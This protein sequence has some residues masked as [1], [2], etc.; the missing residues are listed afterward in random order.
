MFTPIC[1]MRKE[2]TMS[3]KSKLLLAAAGLVLMC[4]CKNNSA[5]L[6]ETTTSAAEV[7]TAK[8]T[9]PAETTKQSET[10]TSKA[11]EETTAAQAEA[12]QIDFEYQPPQEVLDTHFYSDDI[13]AK[14]ECEPILDDDFRDVFN[15]EEAINEVYSAISEILPQEIVDNIYNNIQPFE[16]LPEYYRIKNVSYMKYDLNSDGTDDYYLYVEITDEVMGVMG[17]FH[18]ERVF[19][20]DGD[21]FKPI[22]IPSFNDSRTICYYILSTQTNGVKDIFAFHNSNAPS[23]KY[24]S[25][26]AYGDFTELD[27]RHTFIEFEILSNNILYLN[28]KVS[29]IDAAVGEY[30]TAIQ[31]ADNTYL[32]NSMLYSCYSDGTPRSYIEKSIDEWQSGDFYPSGEGYDFYVELTDEGVEAFTEETNVWRLLDLLEIKYIAVDE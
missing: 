1:N 26:S 32:K 2:N 10:T 21:S 28:M 23:L 12:E 20:A 16:G 11:A 14:I 22:N 17:I 3:I 15:D 9:E 30:Y 31:F 29:V 19:I 27:E 6:P 8:M 24:D 7:T 13:E 25:V 18:F 4:G 5:E